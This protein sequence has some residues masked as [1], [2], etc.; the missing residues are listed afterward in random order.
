MLGITK[1]ACY[2]TSKGLAYISQTVD[3]IKP[4]LSYNSLTS[5]SEDK[6]ANN[7]GGLE[8]YVLCLL[9]SVL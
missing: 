3:V 2:S 1:G 4:F 5:L 7:T 6:S 9:T 8:E